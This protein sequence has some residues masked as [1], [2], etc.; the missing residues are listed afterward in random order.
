[1]TEEE[2]KKELEASRQT[3]A[4]FVLISWVLSVGLAGIVGYIIGTIR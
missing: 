1:M 4:M 2:L 3:G